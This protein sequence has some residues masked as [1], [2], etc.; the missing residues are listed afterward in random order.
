MNSSVLFLLWWVM[1]AAV[2][3]R[4][5]RR[6]RLLVVLAG[7]WS[8]A[9]AQARIPGPGGYVAPAVGSGYLHSRTLTVNH[10]QVGGSTLSNFP[11]LV[12]TTLGASRIQNASC[13]DVIF[14]SDSGGTMKLPWEVESCT[15]SSGAIIAWVGLTSISAT[16]DTVFY[17]FYDNTAIVSAQNT[18]VYA[19]TSV[20]DA[21]YVGVWHLGA[22][23]GVLSALDSTTHGNNGTIVNATS[24]PGQ[25]GSGAQLSVSP[26]TYIDIGAGI[27]SLTPSVVTASGWFIPSTASQSAYAH[28]VVQD[29]ALPRV[30]PWQGYNLSLNLNGT[31]G[32]ALGAGYNIY[33][34][35][36][37]NLTTSTTAAANTSVYLVLTVDSLHANLYVNGAL[38]TNSPAATNG[39]ISYAGTGRF[40]IGANGAAT[41]S[42]AAENAA[43]VAD[44]IRVSNIARSAG[45]ITAEYNNQK[46]SSTFLTVG[47]EI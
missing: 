14:T 35:S 41:S 1:V 11:L 36:Q 9:H 25:I 34:G 22:A 19:P 10:T 47:S 39:P 6:L 24:A 23:S 30:A 15:Q 44:E 40:R 18:G 26:S 29:Y 16:A 32:G 27:S 42:T 12:S 45:W 37:A 31:A 43:G 46:A 3:E 8:M 13:Y 28:L 33:S 2:I 4:V 21:N 17:V 38:G 5:P 20:W 7:Y